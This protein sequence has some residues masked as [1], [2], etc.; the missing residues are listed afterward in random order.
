MHGPNLA[1][2]LDKSWP[3]HVE[4]QSISFSAAACYWEV[5]S[6]GSARPILPLHTAYSVP[7]VWVTVA[8]RWCTCA[9]HGYFLF[10][11][12]VR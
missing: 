12:G 10:P 3:A 9:V 8:L 4:F 5:R 7:L 1:P 11:W 2:G 6:V